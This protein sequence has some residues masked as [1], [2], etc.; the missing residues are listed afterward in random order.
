[1][2]R[3][4][5]YPSGKEIVY[6]V[7]DANRITRVRLKVGTVYTNLVSAIIYRPNGPIASMLYGD[8]FTQTRTYDNS[9]RLTGVTDSLA[10]S[11]LRQRPMA[12][13]GATT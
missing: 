12:M 1:M 6:D 10:A 2:E 13:R 8:G 7:D 3:L 5:Q 9:Y 11:L 4:I